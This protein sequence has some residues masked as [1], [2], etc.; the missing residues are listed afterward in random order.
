MA[1]GGTVPEFHQ[2]RYGTQDSIL[3]IYYLGSP[4]AYHTLEIIIVI[5]KFSPLGSHFEMG[6]NTLQKQGRREGFGNIIDSS[7]VQALQFLVESFLAVRKIT[8]ISL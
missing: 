1:P 3:E 8:G 4:F 7:K 2:F 5:F 6:F